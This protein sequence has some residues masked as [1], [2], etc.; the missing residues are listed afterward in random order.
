[1][2][3]SLS[4]QAFGQG[5][6]HRPAALGL[7]RIE[8]HQRGGESSRQVD[9]ADA[10]AEALFDLTKELGCASVGKKH[11]TFFEANEEVRSQELF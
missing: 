8:S 10:D 9:A 2:E 1:M 5:R 3:Y 4:R 7:A 6:A 11:H